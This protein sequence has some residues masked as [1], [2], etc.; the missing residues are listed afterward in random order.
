M[1]E[2]SAI[3]KCI[4]Y[5]RELDEDACEITAAAE[6]ELAELLAIKARMQLYT[7]CEKLMGEDLSDKPQGE[8]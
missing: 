8:E 6:R 7:A 1:S 4:D 5:V 3:E 2:Q